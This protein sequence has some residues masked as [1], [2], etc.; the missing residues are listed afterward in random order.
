M[1]KFL[2]VILALTLAVGLAVPAAAAEELS[3]DQRLA[4]VTLAVKEALELDTEGYESFY[5]DLSENVLAPEWILEWSG[6]DGYI[7]VTATEEGKV[8][9][10]H[11]GD[12]VSSSEPMP[13]GGSFAPTFP[14][15]DP[16]AATAVAEALVAR[17]LDGPVE[18][19]QLTMTNDP[20]QLGLTNYRF[21]GDIY[22]N[23]LPSP[24]SL[25]VTVRAS[26]NVVTRFYRDDLSDS[27]MNEVP[28]PDAATTADQA[29]A[30]LGTTLALR[31]EYVLNE[32]GDK[33]I[34]R[35]LPEHGDEYYVDAVTGELVNLTEL[36]EA[37]EDLKYGG[38]FAGGAMN[39][40]ATSAPEA[41][42][43]RLTDAELAGIE[44]LEGVQ[45][46][47]A[48][49]AALREAWPQ[50]GLEGYTLARATYTVA[51]EE[52][53]FETDPMAQPVPE[54]ETEA[55]TEEAKVTC[56]LIY[57]KTDEVGTWRR[58]VTVDGRTAGLEGLYS[59]APYSEEHDRTVTVEEAQAAAEEF[60][61]AYA[62][63]E[64][65]KC[66]LYNS[67]DAL[68]KT[69]TVSHGFTYCQMENGYFFTP[70]AISVSVDSVD[71]SISALSVRFDNDVEFDSPE[72]ILTMEEALAAYLAA[73]DVP[74]GYLSIPA[75]IDH[76]AAD[77]R[78][79]LEEMGYGY[80]YL[81]T[82]GYGLE[83]ETYIRG[84]DAKTGEVV[85]YT[86]V[87]EEPLTYDDVAD[88][89]AA[90]T[91]ELLAKYGIGYTGGSFLPDQEM[92][93]LDWLALLVSAE[94][95]RYDGQDAD[96]VYGYAYML[97]LL[98]E[99]E[100]DDDALVTRGD[101][102]KMLLDGA[103]YGQV[104]GLEGIFV[105]SF[106]DQAEIDPD[107]Y[108]YAALA[109]G[110]GLVK[111]DG[112]GAFAGDRTATRAEGAVMLYQYMTLGK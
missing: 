46:K 57:T 98:E 1:K 95:L 8:L 81:L 16:E 106:T 59:S 72:G 78:P 25:S 40:M 17:L 10:Y 39:D 19:A 26:D 24:M 67:A 51:R 21:S 110:L 60:L 61:A 71:G 6:E 101:M 28:A 83:T 58:T 66:A 99:S 36:Y 102:V 75:S 88:C 55:E 41:E 74:L 22:L 100:R 84:I 76:A 38:D 31:L 65:A 12:Y 77:V 44:K 91:V 62:G 96:S 73:H 80:L 92:T 93:Q 20:Y 112:E 87:E 103:G 64:F 86:Y 85:T 18:T 48:L 63:E 70:N 37:L 29:A 11:R 42:A 43:G 27:H 3:H 108:G 105:C 111:G 56:V 32:E 5:G 50:L 45:T 30:L 69:R 34:L 49:D 33:A 89:W 107:L 15:G 13:F 23:G 82:L 109:Q 14:E 79:L 7:S 97:N 9:S 4:A 94:G 52:E 53:K 54:A 104:A 2:S 90:E 47:E 35:Y 68:E